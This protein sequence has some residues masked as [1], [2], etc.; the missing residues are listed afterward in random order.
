MALTLHDITP[1]GLCIAT[2]E[3]FDARRY[4]LNFCDHLLL[5][6]KDKGLMQPVSNMKRELNSPDSQRKFLEGHK[7]AI[8]SN[9]DKIMSLVT[10]R[11][12]TM[13]MR[14]TENVVNSAKDLMQRVMFAT[15]FDDIA[16]LEPMFKSGV[17]LPVYELFM[18][19]MKRSGMS[20]V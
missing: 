14:M 20:V 2:Q 15:S 9:V 4:Q 19:Y 1:V 18:N 12:N 5:R 11:Y 17:T 3:L 16:R 7:A 13:D 6:S 10:A 8:I